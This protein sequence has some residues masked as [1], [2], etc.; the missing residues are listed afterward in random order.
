MSDSVDYFSG[1]KNVKELRGSDFTANESGLEAFTKI[2]S[3]DMCLTAILFYAP[4]CPHCKDTSPI[5]EKVAKACTFAKMCAVNVEHSE[6]KEA[7]LKLRETMPHII[8]S[9]P[10]IWYYV[11]GEAVEKFD[12]SSRKRSFDAIM[13]DLKRLK[14]KCS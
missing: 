11:N 10:T 6:N 2:A 7:V 5:W 13:G 4:W 3:P 9:Y 1:S 12:S 14:V 8:P